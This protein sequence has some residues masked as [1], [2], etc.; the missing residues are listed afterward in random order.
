MRTEKT[1]KGKTEMIC[2]PTHQLRPGSLLHPAPHQNPLVSLGNSLQLSF[3]WLQ[4]PHQ[5]H[6]LFRIDEPLTGSVM[7][8]VG[9][10]H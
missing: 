4:S 1:E 10:G 5:S 6:S 2:S 9:G 7:G 8:K 3:S